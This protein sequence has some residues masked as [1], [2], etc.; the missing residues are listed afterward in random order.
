MIAQFRA[1]RD[2]VVEGLNAIPGI[3]C[4]PP[5][6]AF[7]A[8]PNVT[9]ACRRLGL[10]IAEELQS[11]LLHRGGVAVLARTCF[12]SR[13]EGEVEEY[14]RIS[15]ANSEENLREGLRRIREVV[16]RG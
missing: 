1:R 8:F 14:I 5:Q 7:Y 9:G 15:F 4:H 3:R 10:S 2:L 13:N 16:E 6:G 12:C 11:T